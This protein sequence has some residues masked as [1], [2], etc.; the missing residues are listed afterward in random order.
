MKTIKELF[1]KWESISPYSGG[2]LL[3][4]DDHPLLFHIGYMSES[5]KCFVVLN[6]GKLNKVS[7]S[8]AI[9]VENVLLDNNTY[10]LRFLLNYPSLDELFVKL[11]WDLMTV[12]KDDSNPL[13]RIITQYKMWLKLLHQVG[14]GLLPIHV[15]KGLI[16]ELLYLSELID[17]TGEKTALNSWIGPEGAD[18]DFSFIDG[19]AEIKTTI[20]SGSTIHVS[21]LQQ[22]DRTDDGKLIVYFLDKTTSSGAST[23]S[24]NEI[25]NQV[26][27][28]MSREDSV[29]LF[30]MKL[31]RYGYQDKNSDEYSS[32]RFRLGEI[33]R[34][35]VLP[36]FPRLT[37]DNVS[38]SII[39][40]QYQIDLPSVE[41]YRISEDCKW[42]YRIFIKIS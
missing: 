34:Y 25:V 15:Q 23:L 20:I 41:N 42:T 18:Q 32:C 10:A 27:S 6:T 28:K 5:Q 7:S 3:V 12:S 30:K 13:G 8:T 24:L 16:G 37:K 22:F 4:S 29:D 40:A 38:P 11:C 2:F 14:N 9:N 19:W 1:E 17:T 21:S 39:E 31:A 26:S 33:R 36:D 35:N